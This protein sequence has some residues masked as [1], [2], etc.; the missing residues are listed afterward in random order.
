MTLF[1]EFITTN[2][3]R[4]APAKVKTYAATSASASASLACQAE[5]VAHL[6]FIAAARDL[7]VLAKLINRSKSSRTPT[8]MSPK[9]IAYSFEGVSPLHF[10]SFH[11][12]FSSPLRLFFWSS[13]QVNVAL[14]AGCVLIFEIVWHLSSKVF[15]GVA[16]SVDDGAPNQPS[17]QAVSPVSSQTAKS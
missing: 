2:K 11:L 3:S 17:S 15:P 10:L 7:S 4:A 16:M 13:L 1:C 5:L 9:W 8:V 14:G 6:V 12:F